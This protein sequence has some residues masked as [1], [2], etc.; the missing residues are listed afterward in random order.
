MTNANQKK[1]NRLFI[2]VIG[3]IS[4]VASDS[5]YLKRFEGSSCDPDISQCLLLN[6]PVIPDD[7]FEDTKDI[8]SNMVEIA[9]PAGKANPEPAGPLNLEGTGTKKPYSKE[10]WEAAIS[11]FGRLH[12]D[13]EL[14]DVQSAP[15]NEGEGYSPTNLVVQVIPVDNESA[16]LDLYMECL[17]RFSRGERDFSEQIP[18]SYLENDTAFL[19]PDGKLF[20]RAEAADEA[21]YD[22]GVEISFRDLMSGEYELPAPAVESDMKPGA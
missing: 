13:S 9:S 17:D 11:A 2:R 18:E 16:A 7:T 19:C 10:D 3:K 4:D 14:T 22:T 20:S 6:V 5:A 21:G 12:K 15:F 8:I 1:E